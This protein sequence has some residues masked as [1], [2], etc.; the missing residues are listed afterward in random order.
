MTETDWG[1]CVHRLRNTE[2]CQQPPLGRVGRGKEGSHLRA[3]R[4][5]VDLGH[6]DFG[7]LAS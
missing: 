1:C 2:D 5:R 4:E 3:F 7:L 6:L